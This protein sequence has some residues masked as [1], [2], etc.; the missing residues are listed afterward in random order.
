[1][2]IYLYLI[3]IILSRRCPSAKALRKLHVQL[4]RAWTR[5]CKSKK[6]KME[7]ADKTEE[8][9][10]LQTKSLQQNTRNVDQQLHRARVEQR[11]GMAAAGCRICLQGHSCPRRPRSP[12][13]LQPLCKRNLCCTSFDFLHCINAAQKTLFTVWNKG[14][15]VCVSM[16]WREMEGGVP[17]GD[18]FH[19]LLS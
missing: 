5:K 15:Q 11:A 3:L 14:L 16:A 13:H 17:A 19:R 1:M 12:S 8:G 4:R 9:N 18:E 10:L 2:S 6:R 7:E